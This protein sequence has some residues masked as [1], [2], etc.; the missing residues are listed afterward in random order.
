M[1]NKKLQALIGAI[2][3]IYTIIQS[4]LRLLTCWQQAVEKT[5]CVE[6]VSCDCK[7]KKYL[8]SWKI[9]LPWWKITLGYLFVLPYNLFR[10]ILCTTL[11]WLREYQVIGTIIVMLL[12]GTTFYFLVDNRCSRINSEIMMSDKG[13][14]TGDNK[15]VFVGTEIEFTLINDTT[16]ISIIRDVPEVWL[17]Y[18]YNFSEIFKRKQIN[19]TKYVK[20]LTEHVY[21]LTLKDRKSR[22]YLKYYL[23][24]DFYNEVRDDFGNQDIM[25]ISIYLKFTNDVT[26]KIK[27]TKNYKLNREIFN[28]KTT[29]NF[30]LDG[31]IGGKKSN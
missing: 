19:V 5:D 15:D 22:I 6:D 23:T 7:K 21:P 2:K 16:T 8:N 17:E 30:N 11:E 18:Q 27:T 25:T 1:K 3:N 4:K 29:F 12:S 9:N 10:M 24:T 14:K 26:K 20:C 13:F 28:S 31:I